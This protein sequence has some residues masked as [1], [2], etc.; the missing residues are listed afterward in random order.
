ML[1][2]VERARTFIVDLIT[3]T[4]NSCALHH[5][6]I[7]SRRKFYIRLDDGVDIG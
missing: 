3:R 5:M 2:A 7:P 4:C 6:E 1:W